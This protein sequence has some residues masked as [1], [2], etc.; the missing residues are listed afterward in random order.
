MKQKQSTADNSVMIVFCLLFFL[1]SFRLWGQ[2]PKN[3][4]GGILLISSY[5]PIK[6]EGQHVISSFIHEMKDYTN[7]QIHVEYMDCES[8]PVFDTWKDWMWQLFRAYKTKPEVVVL[9]G[10]EAWSAYRRVCPEEWR[11]IPVVLGGVK[12]RFIDYSKGEDSVANI[13]NLVLTRETFNGFKVTGYYYEDYIEENIKLIKTLQP[14]IKRI[15]VCYDNRYS[16]LFFKDYLETLF[17]SIDS[18]DLCYL[19][20]NELTTPML[21]DSI[22]GMDDSYALLTAGW[23]TD[24]VRYPHSYSMFH[25]ELARFTSKP[26]YEIADQGEMNMN[27]VGGYF[28]KGKDLGK[29]LAHLTYDVLTKG[30]ENSSVFQVTPSAPHCYINYPTF[31]KVGFDKKLLPSDTVFY[32]KKPSLLE[33][34]PV[35][36]LLI[37]F[38][39]LLMLIL[40]LVVLFNRKRREM[41]YIK[42]NGRMMKLISTM[43]DMAIIY[44]TKLN[45]VDVVNSAGHVLNEVKREELIGLNVRNIVSVHSLSQEALDELVQNVSDTMATKQIHIFN[46]E[47]L[48]EGVSYYAKARTVPFNEDQVICFVHDITSSIVAEREILKLKTFLQSIVDNLPVGLFIKDV[49]NE[50]RYLFYNNKVSEYYNKDSASMLGK[51]DF[52]V[53]DPSAEQFRKEDELVVRSDKPLSFNHV[54]KE[55]KD[56]E[57]IRWGIITKTRLF[58][59]NGDCYVIGTVADTTEIRKNE[60]ELDNIREELSMAMD[61]GSLSAWC[62]D[63][64]L[65]KFSSLY[66]DTL[67]GDGLFDQ[68]HQVK[69][70]PDDKE[71]YRIFMERLSSGISVK[72]REIFRFLQDGKY[73]WFETFAA[74]LKSDKTGEIV[75]IIGTQKNITNE[76]MQQQ[77]LEENKL[78]L[79]FTLE[80]AQIISWEYNVDT[81]MFYSPKSTVIEGPNISLDG[82]LAYIHPDDAPLLREGLLDLS[83]GR[84]PVMDV[85]IRTIESLGNRWFEMHAVP[86]GYG[87]DGR[88]TKLIGL[89]RDITDLKITDELIRLRDKA[90]EANRLKSAFLANMSHEIRTPLNAIV[91]FSNLIAE[92]EDPEEISA[93]VKI[94]ETNNELLL[95]LINDILDLSKIEAG[96]LDFN[97]SNVDLNDVF[98]DLYQIFQSR[99]KEDVRLICELPEENYPLYSEKNRLM[100][101]LSNFLSNACK[102]TFVGTITM[103]YEKDGDWLRFYVSDTG[104]GIA[105][106]NIPHVFERFAKF[107]S[108]V[109]GT[110]LGLSICESIIQSLNG[111][112]G[113]ESEEGKGSTFWFTLPCQ[114]VKEDL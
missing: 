23:Y 96:Q 79:E 45:I 81:Q 25:N 86:Y 53:D 112:I 15:A 6:E 89:R 109:Q 14:H 63:I 74:G 44:D 9:F 54:F 2:T 62:Y 1:L 30:I 107:D 55:E 108:F 92:T 58:D 98:N 106:E 52:E 48:H 102:Y 97:Y 103:G 66:K 13:K 76:M 114:S 113:V 46:Y 51:N 41:A 24:A 88:L 31:K 22:A 78:K 34:H 36:F 18:L 20:G 40:F 56:G 8:F 95:Q 12:N 43:P 105:A 38:G 49:Q 111:K 27:Y 60:M 4:N 21:L 67:V 32:N 35:G 17:E 83:S 42:E 10:G 5:S 59:Q 39:M 69:L 72:E 65:G 64:A 71:K 99:V 47:Y 11:D 91:G 85:Q 16:L 26:V 100:Q 50:F 33:E 19:P 80:A 104:K 77:E 3:E 94:I 84:I 29:D 68:E 82:Y 75:Q 87:E 90:E 28:V 70:H 57:P 7:T 93:Y 73:G 110:G 61:A 37:L 101:I